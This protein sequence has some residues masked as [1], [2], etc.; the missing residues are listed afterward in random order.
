VAGTLS[1]GIIVMVGGKN[2]LIVTEKFGRAFIANI[3]LIRALELGDSA[4]GN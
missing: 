3:S 4:V 1:E 2:D